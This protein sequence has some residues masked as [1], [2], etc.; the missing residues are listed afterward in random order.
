MVYPIIERTYF[1]TQSE[2]WSF[3]KKISKIHDHW[4]V[5]NYGVEEKEGSLFFF[6]ETMNDP[7]S[8]K[9]ELLRR[10]RIIA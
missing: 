1:D 5:S 9:S 6:V 4:I 8:P 2:A 7:F 10:A 3:A